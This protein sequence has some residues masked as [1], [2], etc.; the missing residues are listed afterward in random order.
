MNEQLNTDKALL[1]VCVDYNNNASGPATGDVKLMSYLLIKGAHVNRAS[2]VNDTPL[3]TATDNGHCSIAE[4]AEQMRICQVSKKDTVALGKLKWS[5]I[6]SQADHAFRMCKW[7]LV[8]Q[9]YAVVAS[10]W[11]F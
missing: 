9:E 5:L 8:F 7:S 4:L 2:E 11:S 6:N 10:Y 1:N 3:Q